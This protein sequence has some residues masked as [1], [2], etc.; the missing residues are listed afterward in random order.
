MGISVSAG[1]AV[2]LVGV[3]L[4]LGVIVP[5]ML[6][7]HDRVTS[8]ADERHQLQTD[9]GLTSIHINSTM[10]DNGSRT[11]EVENSGTTSLSLS[12]TTVLVDNAYVTMDNLTVA[13]TDAA[14][15]DLWLPGEVIEF[16]VDEEGTHSL[17]VVT[18]NGIKDRI[19]LGEE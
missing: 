2:I 19:S 3:F 17:V 13:G 1:T 5:G 15:T 9:R 11:V 6:N 10:V 14:E 4:M 8:A 18:E 7:A 16:T 12:E